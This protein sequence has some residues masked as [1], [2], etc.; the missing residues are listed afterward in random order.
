MELLPD[1]HLLELVCIAI[2]CG[3]L[4]TW[5]ARRLAPGLGM[6]DVPDGRRKA[7]RHAT[8]LLGGVAVYVGLLGMWPT[9][10]WVGE[11]L[12]GDD[13]NNADFPSTLLLC[14]GLYCLLGWWDDRV[15]LRPWQKFL[16]QFL[17]GLPFIFLHG[18]IQSVDL[19]GVHLAL[20]SFGVPVTIFWLLAC[21]NAINLI[22]GLDGLASSVV[23]IG[24]VTIGS[25]SL[26]TGN[27]GVATL[28]L[29]L[30]GVLV[31]F[32]IHNLPPAKIFLGDAGSMPLGFLL[33][34]LS[35]NSL[36]KTAVGLTL[37][38][39]VVIMSVP[40]FDTCMAILRRKLNGRA[41]T[42]P[43]RQHIHHVLLDRGLTP[44]Q[45]LSTI[46]LVCLAIAGAAIGS[47]YCQQ[48]M[49]AWVVATSI[50]GLLVCGRV[51]GHHEMMLVVRRIGTIGALLRQTYRGRR[52][53]SAPDQARHVSAARTDLHLGIEKND[54]ES[55]AA[56]I[57]IPFPQTTL[58]PRRDED[59][60]KRHAA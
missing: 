5:L 34:A 15:G 39:P 8:P 31:G 21:V 57:L 12:P 10:R 32:L 35:I 23:L 17:A 28:S 52:Y 6:M 11:S 50:I 16:G 24:V 47:V 22:D 1:L 26:M 25:I 44:R 3:Y 20:G 29:T 14:A 53:G 58:D 48:D 4:L 19:L 18:S 13:L 7:H 30:A 41:I 38:L 42:E 54:A 60:E 37:A 2:G 59:R 56:Q 49:I 9:I 46:A 45:T 40:M 43:D 36:S 55:L 51:F 27:A 33:A